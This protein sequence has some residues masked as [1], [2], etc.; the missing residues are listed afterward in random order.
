MLLT[1][2]ADPNLRQSTDYTALMCACRVGCLESVELLLVSSADL[3]LQTPG[4]LT[5]LDVAAFGGHEDIVDLIH[6]VELSQSSS[7][8][9]VLTSKEI[10]ASVD[11]AAM[12]FLNKA[13]KK[14]LGERTE[15]FISAQ[16][17]IVENILPSKDLLEKTPF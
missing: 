9:P 4:G 12:S 8:S 15:S 2:G 5:A 3:S 1:S 10:A 6:A 17:K 11:N 7:T 16:Y 14:M 13:M